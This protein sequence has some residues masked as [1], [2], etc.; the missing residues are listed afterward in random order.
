MPA[1]NEEE[2][3]VETVM[4][5]KAHPFVDEVIVVDNNSADKT[6]ILAKSAG[7][8]VIREKRQ[9]YGF[10]CQTALKHVTGDLIVLTE[11]DNSFFPDD[12]ELLLAYIPY[13]DIGKGARSNYHLISPDAEWTF[14]LMFGN[15]LLAKYM[16]F[17][18][19]VFKS[20]EDV[21]MREVGGTF[22]IITR[23]ALNKILPYLT[24][25]KGAF[26]PDMVTIALRKKLK[27]IEIPVR[28]RGRLGVSK[29]TGNRKKAVLLAI[30]MMWIITKNRFKKLD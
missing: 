25:G 5:F 21:S 29:I 19:L 28:Y 8:M 30:R 11:S 17:L 23:E 10:A 16:Q 2:G 22:R 6:A 4:G 12:L 3:I 13:F 24:E 14:G 18:F 27:I 26:L 15:W 7:A 20:V 1:Y 9:G